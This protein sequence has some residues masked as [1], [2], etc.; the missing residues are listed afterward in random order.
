MAPI[1]EV[2]NVSK[3][4]KLEHSPHRETFREYLE[5]KVTAPWRAIRRSKTGGNKPRD[6]RFWALKDVSLDVAPGEIVGIIGRNGAG[7][8]TLLKVLSR[9]TLPTSGSVRV[10]GRMGSLLEV[11][12][13]F[14]PELSGRENIF[15]NGAILGM[16]KEEIRAQFD[17]IVDFAEVDAFLDTPVK[18]YSSGMY[19]RL[20]FSVAAHLNP[21]ILLVDEV[22]AV[23]DLAFQR[24]C[25]GKM[26]EVSRSGRTILFIS[27]NMAAIEGLCRRGIVLERG[28]VAFDGTVEQAVNFYAAGVLG[29]RPNQGYLIDLTNVEP[30]QSF[31][32]KLL[33]SVELYTDG[34]EP[35][36]GALRIGSRL[37]MRVHFDLPTPTESFNIGIGFND[38]AETRRLFT[39]HSLFEPERPDGR[40]VGP[41][42]FTCD[43]P[44]FTL[45]PGD[46]NVR[47]WMDIGNVEADLI[48]NALQVTVIESDYYGTGKAPWNGA[49]VLPH[50]WHLETMADVERRDIESG[51]IARV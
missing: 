14:H 9:I 40:Y 18:H 35:L 29:S 12:T 32:G 25:L 20:A 6:E 47:I 41:Q 28:G 45:M 15:L 3:A 2:H 49:V 11:G 19:V 23:G 31:G 4:Y 48:N 10:R 8:S 42:T 43:I 13:G 50:R 5:R 24:K 27:H 1:L 34:G 38:G 16:R 51:V 44:S 7:K 37:T 46:Y 26:A 17:S 21:E 39:A 33:K 30:R 22:L 36:H